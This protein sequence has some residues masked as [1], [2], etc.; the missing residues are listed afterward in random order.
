[1]TTRE[2]ETMA[3]SKAVMD[4]MK[5]LSEIINDENKTEEKELLILKIHNEIVFDKMILK[6]FQV[7]LDIQGLKSF[8]YLKML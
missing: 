4:M 5:R 7:I 6:S 3:K 1:M 2:I 8:G